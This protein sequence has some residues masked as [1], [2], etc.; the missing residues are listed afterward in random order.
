MSKLG[1]SGNANIMSFLTTVGPFLFIISSLIYLIYLL[2]IYFNKI[3]S[4]H[5][6]NG[7]N[8]FSNIIIVLVIAQLIVFYYGSQEKTFK[9][10]H[11]LSKIYGMFLYLVGLLTL[12][13]IFSLG[14]ILQYF[15]TD[16]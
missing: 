16:G 3:T 15:S 1:T 4:G 9:T 6:S 7:Y 5:V 8:T 10:Y 11:T 2:S 12:L 13:S 14:T